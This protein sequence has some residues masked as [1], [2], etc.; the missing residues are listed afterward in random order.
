M[1]T[2]L[3]TACENCQNPTPTDTLQASKE[4]IG[5]TLCRSCLANL[6]MKIE[7]STWEAIQLYF[8]LKKK[9]VPT[10]LVN[11]EGYLVRDISMKEPQVDITVNGR[12]TATS[13]EED[14]QNDADYHAFRKGFLTVRIPSQLVQTDMAETAD[15]ISAFLHKPFDEKKL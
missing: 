3:P 14:A 4:E 11:N 9:G 5:H 13:G 6:K 12:L 2:P 1:N 8:S 15:Y 7:Q 10:S